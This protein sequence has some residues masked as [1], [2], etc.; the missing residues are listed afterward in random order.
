MLLDS[1]L[2]GLVTALLVEE[3]DR[4]SPWGWMVVSPGMWLDAEMP[5]GRRVRRPW[6]EDFPDGCREMLGD[7]EKEERMRGCAV[8]G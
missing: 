5:L 3:R 8:R 6:D 2:A 7:E 1:L 4:D